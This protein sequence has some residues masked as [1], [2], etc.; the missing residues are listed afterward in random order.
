VDLGKEVD[1]EEFEGKD[2]ELKKRQK[3][4]TD[5]R[6]RAK[7]M[8]TLEK[9]DRVWVKESNSSRGREG[10]VVERG[11]QPESYWVEVEGRIV[12]RNR[13]HCRKLFEGPIEGDTGEGGRELQWGI[14][15]DNE[16]GSDGDTEASG[17]E[18]ERPGREGDTGDRITTRGGRV[19][20]SRHLT[21][22]YV[23]E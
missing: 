17:E 20:S 7:K 15:G 9:G 13:A 3:V 1:R 16:R 22:E 4:Y 5:R 10:T 12:R 21:D 23:W 2:A 11:I 18:G 19:V 14:P 8:E 6:R